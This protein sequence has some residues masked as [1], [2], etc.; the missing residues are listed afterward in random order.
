MRQPQEAKVVLFE[1]QSGADGTTRRS[2]IE[3]DFAAC[4]I[5]RIGAQRNRVAKEKPY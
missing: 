2:L 1:F 5:S 4:F 3:D